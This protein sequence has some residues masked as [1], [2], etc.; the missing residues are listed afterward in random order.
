MALSKFALTLG[1]PC[2][3]G[4]GI[5]A[6][7]A[8]EAS[9]NVLDRLIF[10]GN[11]RNFQSKFQ[12]LNLKQPPVWFCGKLENR[13]FFPKVTKERASEIVKGA[14]REVVVTGV[15]TGLSDVANHNH[16]THACDEGGNC[17]FATGQTYAETD[18]ENPGKG[19]F[20]FDTGE[21]YD[22]FPGKICAE[23]GAA[24]VT[25]IEVAHRLC[26]SGKCAGMVN[27]PIG[28]KAIRLAGSPF[29]GHTD[30]LCALSRA[31]LSR[32]AMVWE[33]FR[34]VMT[35]LHVAWRD[36]PAMI[37]L[38]SVYETIRL[39]H[40][41]F[42][43]SSNPFPKIAIAGLNPHAGEDGL[44]GDEEDR[45]IKPAIAKFRN[46]NPNLGG[47]FPADSMFTGKMRT[48]WDVFVTHSHDQGLIAI[49]ALGGLDCVNVTLGLPYIRTA[50][51]HGTAYDLAAGSDYY[52]GGLSAA[53]QCAFQMSA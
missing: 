3:I 30:M 23:A 45:A 15:K 36:V 53:V 18:V 38:E 24:A 22:F 12:M 29:S 31:K 28:K 17:Q 2:G 49:K 5:A 4:P 16:G 7:L 25:A 8:A 11:F 41:N 9:Q 43:T 32:M 51:G 19:V 6:R 52:A 47:P 50:V 21:N 37:T 20:F 14:E 1:D 40:E 44:F 34:V 13:S 26:A 10:I 35:T 27:G 39:A 33:N 48:D 42:C 46:V